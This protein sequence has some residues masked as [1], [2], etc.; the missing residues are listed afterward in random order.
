MHELLIYLSLWKDGHHDS[1]PEVKSKY[2]PT[3][4]V[5]NPAPSI[6][7]SK[8]MKNS[9]YSDFRQFLMYVQMFMS[10]NCLFELVTWGYKNGVKCDSWWVSPPRDWPVAQKRAERG[11]SWY[12]PAVSVKTL[13]TF[14]CVVMDGP[15]CGPSR[16]FYPSRCMCCG[17]NPRLKTTPSLPSS[18][19]WK[20]NPR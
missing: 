19:L 4:A 14:Q 16:I 7:L 10:L 15:I 17:K 5:I 9:V 20:T 12:D 3:V 6:M 2:L 18:A 11:P 13:K 1:F 8:Q